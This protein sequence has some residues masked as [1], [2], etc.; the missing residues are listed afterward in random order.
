MYVANHNRREYWIV[1]PKRKLV[2]V[3]YFEGNILSVQY[4]FYSTVKVNIYDDLY[5][6]FTE[7]DKQLN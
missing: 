1:D 5:I 2:I 7:I 4:D 3:N 6:D